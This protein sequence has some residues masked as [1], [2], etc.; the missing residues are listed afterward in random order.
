METLLVRSPGRSAG[1][2]KPTQSAINTCPRRAWVRE[3]TASILLVSTVLRG[4]ATGPVPGRSDA[5]QTGAERHQY[6]PTQSMGTRSACSIHWSPR[7]AVETLFVRSPDDLNVRQSLTNSPQSGRH[8]SRR[9]A[10]GTSLNLVSMVRRGDAPGPVPGR[11]WLIMITAH[12]STSEL[13]P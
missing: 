4:D 6:V 5:L 3:S 12:K 11:L 9:R 2:S 8:R 10:I 1:H 13:L 7:S